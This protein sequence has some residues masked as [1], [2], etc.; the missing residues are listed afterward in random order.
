[1][2]LQIKWRFYEWLQRNIQRLRDL[3]AMDDEERR[4]LLRSLGDEQYQD[5]MNVC[6]TLPNVQLVMRSEG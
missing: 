5:V 1:M 6:A 4:A 2:T 3:V